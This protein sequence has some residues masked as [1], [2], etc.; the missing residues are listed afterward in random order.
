MATTLILASASPRRQELL[1]QIAIRYH[2]HPTAIDE[3]PY[4]NEDPLSYVKRMAEEKSA[5]C[6]LHFPEHTAI[7]AADTSVV[8]NQHIL[9]KPT[10]KHDA[11][12][13]LRSLSGITHWVYTAVS[14]RSHKHDLVVSKSEVT[15]KPLSDAEIDAYW[16][17]GE[18]LDKAGAYAIQG[19]G[20]IFVS[21]ING[22]FSGIVGLPLYETSQLLAL[23]GIYPTV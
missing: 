9:G 8:V 20:G 14:L 7:L 19:R 6:A 23:H 3:T 11:I 2:V 21:H 12:R 5:A 22:S 1:N 10:D 16:Q 13:M 15:F 17:S 18:P 4:D